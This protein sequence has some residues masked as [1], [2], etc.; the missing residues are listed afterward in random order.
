MRGG[1]RIDGKSGAQVAHD[2]LIAAGM[3][4][5]DAIDVTNAMVK[6]FSAMP[7]GHA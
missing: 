7:R 5:A 6:V 3:N 1:I 2:E 4:P